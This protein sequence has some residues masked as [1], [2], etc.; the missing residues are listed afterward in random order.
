M[1]R[2]VSAA[3]ALLVAGVALSGCVI[4]HRPYGHQRHSY[5]KPYAHWKPHH[6]HYH[7]RHY[8]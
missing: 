5:W 6:H 2:H 8:R 7:D 4:E 3:L 1:K